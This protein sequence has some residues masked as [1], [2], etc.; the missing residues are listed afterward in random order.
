MKTIYRILSKQLVYFGNILK[1]SKKINKH[2]KKIVGKKGSPV[3][4]LTHFLFSLPCKLP[5]EFLISHDFPTLMLMF[6]AKN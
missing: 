3:D 1:W 5:R 4:L 2:A 6:I